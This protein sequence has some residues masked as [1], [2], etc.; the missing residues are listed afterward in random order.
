[1][2]RKLT[3]YDAGCNPEEPF[4]TDPDSPAMQTR[5]V[6]EAEGQALVAKLRE[7]VAALRRAEEVAKK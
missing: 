2:A 5:E 1:M 4:N 7:A 3:S 6:T